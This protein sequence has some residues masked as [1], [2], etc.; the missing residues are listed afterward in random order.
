MKIGELATASATAVDTIRFYER[1]GLLPAPARTASNYRIYGPG[2]L[3]RL[4]FIRHCRSLDMSLDEI[5][6]L[7]RLQDAPGEGCGE[8]NALLD[9]HIGHVRRRIEELAALADELD[10]LR[11]RCGEARA[12]SECGILQE[13][14][15]APGPAGGAGAQHVAG[16]HGRGR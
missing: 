10:R 3:A 11:A 7:L 8:A 13:L 12:A 2:H 9:A 6:L 5:R 15:Q 1:E 4:R 14:A 16:V